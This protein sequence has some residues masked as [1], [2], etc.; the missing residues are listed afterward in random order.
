MIRSETIPSCLCGS[1]NFSQVFVYE[2]P[3]E[4]EIR[5]DFSSSGGYHREVLRCRTCGH[6]ISV[7]E[8]DDRR[9]YDGQYVNST[10]GQNGLRTAFDRIVSLD[11][12]KSDNQGRVR[13]ILEFSRQHFTADAARGRPSL[14]D[15]GSGLCV[16]PY[17]MKAEGWDCTALDP[18]PRSVRHAEEVAGVTGI[19]GDFMAVDIGRTF[20]LVSFNKVLEHVK[21]PVDMLAKA[22]N[23]LKADGFVYVELPDGEAAVYEG[24]GRE[25]FFIEH[26]HIFSFA[27][28]AVLAAAAGFSATVVE[29]LREPSTKFTLRGFLKPVSPVESP[30]AWS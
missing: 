24:P 23:Y 15:V 12:T 2:T 10:Y 28:L 18:D 1:R 22:R 6:F 5:F 25:E 3:P 16:F 26:H 13:R 7:H 11:P 4:G 20:D 21:N 9:L 29:R 8:M 17:R 14:L 27:S 19:C 30:V